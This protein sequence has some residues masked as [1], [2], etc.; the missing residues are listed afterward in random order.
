MD[1]FQWIINYWEKLN[2]STLLSSNDIRRNISYWARDE[3]LEYLRW[4]VDE[5]SEEIGKIHKGYM[6]LTEKDANILTKKVFVYMSGL[7]KR[8]KLLGGL[9]FSLRLM[10]YPDI[11]KGNGITPEMIAQARNYPLSEIVEVNSRGFAHCV[12]HFPDRHPSLYTKGGFAYCFSCGWQGDS[13]DIT[14][15]LF[16]LTFVEAVRKLLK[17]KNTKDA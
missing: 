17:G 6:N 5:L 13:I 3:Q 16:N 9:T 11:V 15:K 1:T 14:M 10:E 7:K 4:K 2:D 8:E 12:N